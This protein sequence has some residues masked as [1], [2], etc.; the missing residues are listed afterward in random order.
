MYLTRY[1]TSLTLFIVL[2]DLKVS[3]PTGIARPFAPS[4]FLV[5]NFMNL[6]LVGHIG[7]YLTLSAMEDAVFAVEHQLIVFPTINPENFHL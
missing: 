1:L 3:L 4:E 6:K 7:V 2:I 5:R